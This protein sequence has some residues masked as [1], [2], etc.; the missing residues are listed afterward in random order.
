MPCDG[1][2]LPRHSPTKAMFVLYENENCKVPTPRCSPILLREHG[3]AKAKV[4]VKAMA[5]TADSAVAE[6]VRR[7][8]WY[9]N[10]CGP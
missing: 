6:K 3:L 10:L 2:G 5:L 4:P 8:R 9:K 1:F 7:L